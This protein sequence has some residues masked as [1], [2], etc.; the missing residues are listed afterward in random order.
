MSQAP[1]ARFCDKCDSRL[2]LNL[3]SE[4]ELWSTKLRTFN[5]YKNFGNY[6]L[7]ILCILFIS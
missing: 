3:K 4:C 2:L 5:F 1:N 6:D 7:D